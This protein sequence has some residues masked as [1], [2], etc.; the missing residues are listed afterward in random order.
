MANIQGSSQSGSSLF[1]QHNCLPLTQYTHHTRLL[2]CLQHARPQS[3]P[4]CLYSPLP[5]STCHN[6]S[7]L[8]RAA[9]HITISRS[10]PDN[11]SHSPWTRSA[12]LAV[13]SHSFLI[14]LILPHHN[15]WLYVS[16]PFANNKFPKDRNRMLFI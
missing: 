6:P 10:F 1:L 3:H 13:C 14:I 9:L 15:L 7:H 2:P 8:S 16:A 4:H 11:P 12:L 5:M